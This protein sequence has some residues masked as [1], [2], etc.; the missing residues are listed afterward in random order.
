MAGSSLCC[1]ARLRT[2]IAMWHLIFDAARFGAA[3][4]VEAVWPGLA[5]FV[6]VA[7]CRLQWSKPT[8]AS[9][10]RDD[11]IAAAKYGHFVG[12][13]LSSTA[14]NSGWS[15]FSAQRVRCRQSRPASGLSLDAQIQGSDPVITGG[16]NPPSSS[17]PWSNPAAAALLLSDP[18]VRELRPTPILAD[19][20]LQLGDRRFPGWLW[21]WPG[22]CA[23][24]FPTRTNRPR[25]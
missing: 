13:Y 25:D 19:Q 10:K 7:A 21:C 8:D 22:H 18:H 1:S 2:P 16:I 14:G 23:P 24:V 9:G 12:W 15:K 11:W 5:R 6:V 4:R 3:A 20:R 17:T